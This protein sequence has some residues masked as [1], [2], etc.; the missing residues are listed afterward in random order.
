M[1]KIPT[2]EELVEL[3]RARNEAALRKTEERYGRYLHSLSYAVLGSD[4]DSDECVNDAL[5][6]VWQ[7]IPPERPRS[8]K[9][10][11]T[12]IVRNVALMKYR[13]KNALKRVESEYAL[14]IEDL[15]DCI[16]DAT[17]TEKA[18]E[19]NALRKILNEFVTSLSKKQRYIFVSRYYLSVPA[20]KIAKAPL[21]AVK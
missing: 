19:N 3:Y 11:I 4:A 21:S 1:E 14:S 13:E 6:A 8:F 20:A 17:D 10:Y 2:D 12:A 7:R 9:A 18:F 16:A 5:Y 15:A